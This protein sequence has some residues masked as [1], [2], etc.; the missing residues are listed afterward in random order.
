MEL[1]PYQLEIAR[2]VVDSILNSRGLTFSVEIARQGGK[3]ELSAH[4]ELLLLTMFMA[5]GGSA[6]KCSSWS[7][8][9]AAAVPT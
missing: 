8:P 6:V 9:A 4:I 5:R 2:A 1:R 7:V 3:N